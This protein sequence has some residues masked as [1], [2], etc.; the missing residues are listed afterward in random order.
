MPLLLFLQPAYHRVPRQRKTNPRARM[1]VFLNFGYNHGR[2]FYRLLN[3][4]TERVAYSRDV[5]WNHLEALGATPIGAAPTES[6]RDIYVLM[7]Q[8]VPVAAP[9]HAPVAAPLAPALPAMP[10][11]PPTP[12]MSN[13]PAR[14]RP[15]VRRE[16]EY[17]R[18]VEMPGRT[19]GEICALHD[20]SRECAHRHGIPLDHVTMASLL[21]KGESTKKTIRQYGASKDSPDLP[22]AHASGLTTP[23]NVTDVEKSPHTDIWRHSMHQ[24]YNG[25]LKD[26]T[27]APGAGTG[28]AIS[29]KRDRCQVGVHTES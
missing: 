19:C 25:L 3:A 24:K 21:A 18:Y 16:S 8:S 27:F 20:A 14:I 22:N 17:K 13:I 11:P 23:N 10:P 9:S 6:P 12:I 5:T 2:D 7:P 1:W 4:D 15:S 28:I 29:R 26:G